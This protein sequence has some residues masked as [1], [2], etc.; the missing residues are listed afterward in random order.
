MAT[1][2]PSL[3]LALQL[4]PLLLLVLGLVAPSAS[5]P[6]EGAISIAPGIE[7]PSTKVW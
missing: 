5:V 6:I 1:P 3:L 4:L 7:A 2:R